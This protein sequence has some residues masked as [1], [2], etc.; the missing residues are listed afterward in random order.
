MTGAPAARGLAAD[1]TRVGPGRS[2]PRAVRG[3]AFRRRADRAGPGAARPHHPRPATGLEWGFS[4]PGRASPWS[5]KHAYAVPR[6]HPLRRRHPEGRRPP[7]AVLRTVRQP[8]RQAGGD[9]ARWSGRRLQRRRGNRDAL[10][11]PGI[12]DRAA[13]RLASDVQHRP[14]GGH[15]IGDVGAIGIY[16]LQAQR[17]QAQQAGV[18]PH[19]A[20]EAAALLPVL[21][22]ELGRGAAH[23]GGA[24]VAGTRFTQYR[25]ARVVV[26]GLVVVI[27][28]V[29]DAVMAVARIDGVVGAAVVEV[30]VMFVITGIVA[31]VVG[32]E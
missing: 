8:G 2:D 22:Q 15:G 31:S 30:A 4:C 16:Q 24:G 7:H 17:D 27:A 13:Q 6:H 3:G 18:A 29:A 23:I 14:Q 12:T 28:V 9:A 25:L 21:V 5:C 26:F 19:F 32:G 20:Q 11:A 10:Q 1:R